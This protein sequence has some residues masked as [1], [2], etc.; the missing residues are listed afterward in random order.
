MVSLLLERNEGRTMFLQRRIV[1][2]KRFGLAI[3]FVLPVYGS[4]LIK[5][6][7]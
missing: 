1:F 3:R 5:K 2:Q 4:C 7:V 6:R